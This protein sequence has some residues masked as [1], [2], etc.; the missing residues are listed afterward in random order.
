[1]TVFLRGG[2]RTFL[3]AAKPS[4]PRTV[5][6]LLLLL[7]WRWWEGEQFAGYLCSNLLLYEFTLGWDP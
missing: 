2:K 6:V 4:G 1:M 7:I 5:G 3:S